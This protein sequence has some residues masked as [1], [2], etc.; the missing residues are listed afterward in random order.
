MSSRIR[1][2]KMESKP[3][4]NRPIWPMSRIIQQ[5]T[6][7]INTDLVSEKH[8]KIVSLIIK[9][10]RVQSLFPKTSKFRIRSTIRISS[11][12][13]LLIIKSRTKSQSTQTSNK[14][15]SS[16]SPQ[17][18]QNMPTLF[19]IVLYIKLYNDQPSQALSIFIYIYIYKYI[20]LYLKSQTNL[21]ERKQSIKIIINNATNLKK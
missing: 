12:L 11:S 5:E 1:L 9:S 19:K 2:F 15:I 20:Y 6:K 7:T 13:S 3:I 16:S 14:S 21:S 10:Y 17:K 8:P 4:T 18:V